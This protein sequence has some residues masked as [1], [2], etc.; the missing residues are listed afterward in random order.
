MHGFYIIKVFWL[1]GTRAREQSLVSLVELQRT[2]HLCWLSFWTVETEWNFPILFYRFERFC[3]CFQAGF[4]SF[5]SWTC[6]THSSLF[7]LS[8][9]RIRRK[10]N[11]VIPTQG[12]IVRERNLRV[13]CLI[14]D[15][16]WFRKGPI[17]S[18]FSR[19]LRPA[20]RVTSSGLERRHLI[21]VRFDGAFLL[22][23]WVFGWIP[24]IVPVSLLGE[25]L[26]DCWG[27][28]GFLSG[29]DEG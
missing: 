20:W 12:M 7:L 27:E 28:W 19:I 23:R 5:W 13:C 26:L 4:V 1:Y 14:P 11:E 3:F 16:P 2:S 29:S 21:E 9:C 22:L 8:F 24:G 25:T 15:S 10:V 6:F 18:A 17:I